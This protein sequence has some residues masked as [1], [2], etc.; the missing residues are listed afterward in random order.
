MP[1]NL[2]PYT[3]P[4][5]SRPSQ[6]WTRFFKALLFFILFNSGCFMINASQFIFLLP[7]RILPFH[8]TKQLYGEGIRYTKGAFGCLLILMCHWFA[9]T[10]IKVTFETKGKGS[11]SQEH[12]SRLIRT[13]YDCNAGFLDL[14]K[15][16]ILTANH[17]IYADWWYMWCLM[18]FVSPQGVHRNVYI[19]LKKS[20]QW[21]PIVGW[22]MQ[23]FNFI[24]LARSWASDKHE[25]ASR[26][27]TLGKQAEQEDYPLCF[28]LY[29]EGTLVSKDT[30]PISKKF[31]DKMGIS[32]MDH[33]LLPRSLG[34]HYSLRSL[35]PRIPDL[36]LLDLTVIYPGI[37]SLAYGQ[38][39]Y[40]LRS[41]FFDGVAPPVIHMH[42]RLFKVA[43]DVPIGDLSATE[44]S[45]IPSTK[46]ENHVV[47]VDIPSDEKAVFDAWLRELWQEKDSDIAA[48]HDQNLPRDMNE[49]FVEIPLKLRHRREYLDAFCFFSPAAFGYFWRQ[50][51]Q[52]I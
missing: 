24:F 42:L 27:A 12:V 44:S 51:R 46:A 37:P 15:K 2:Q 13:Y 52:W 30:R 48:Y 14:P 39:Y 17:Q 43:T 29:P 4:I 18:Y 6:S 34:L 26:L 23:L 50:L 5:S 47:E 35:A 21:L 33:L 9:P 3:R 40:T 45:T 11:F 36:H 38:D 25:L 16:F 22:G 49:Y 28:I 19:T 31:A 1:S 8:F 7:L 41:I 20:L 10:K 32:D